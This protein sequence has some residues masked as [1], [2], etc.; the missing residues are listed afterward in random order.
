MTKREERLAARLAAT[1]DGTLT[2]AAARHLMAQG[3]LDTRAC[4]RRIA[5]RRMDELASGGC[6]RCGAMYAVAEELGCSYAKVKT[7]YY[8]SFQKDQ[9]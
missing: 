4:E 7:L 9:P 1:L 3:L 2:V 8:E 5:R 6:P